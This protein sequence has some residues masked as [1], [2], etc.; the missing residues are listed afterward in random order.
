MFIY[1]TGSLAQWF[2]IYSR[3]PKRHR[4][5]LRGTTKES[6]AT[7]FC[8]SLGSLEG[9]KLVRLLTRGLKNV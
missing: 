5:N 7:H 4:I 1:S 9:K 8:E 3:R 6:S 2:Q